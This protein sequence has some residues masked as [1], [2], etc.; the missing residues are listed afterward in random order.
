MMS[1]FSDISDQ[2]LSNYATF[3]S[4][5]FHIHPGFAGGSHSGHKGAAVNYLCL[6]EDPEWERFDDSLRKSGALVYGTEYQTDSDPNLFEDVTAKSYVHDVPC[7]VCVTV[8]SNVLMIPAKKTCPSGWIKE[9][10]GYLAGGHFEHNAS[11]EYICLD[12]EPEIIPGGTDNNNEKMVWIAEARCGGLKCPPYVNG[13][14]LTC[15]VCSK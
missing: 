10:S 4:I 7:A 15:S 3:L 13:R 14:E 5:T 11:S 12:R 2:H 8:R 6:P 1:H 9:Y